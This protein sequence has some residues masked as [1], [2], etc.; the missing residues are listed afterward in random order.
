MRV[1]GDRGATRTRSR[2]AVLRGP[3][4]ARLRSFHPLVLAGTPPG[5]TTD[6]NEGLPLGSPEAPAPHDAHVMHSP[7]PLDGQRT[8][9]TTKQPTKYS[10]ADA[11]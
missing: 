6:A 5:Y 1:V 11:R 2:S 4:A 7:C 3:S 9:N 8:L 10:V